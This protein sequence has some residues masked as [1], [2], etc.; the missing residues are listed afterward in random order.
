MHGFDWLAI[1]STATVRFERYWYHLVFYFNKSE[2]GREIEAAAVMW[3]CKQAA[4][5]SAILVAFISPRCGAATDVHFD[6]SG[7]VSNVFGDPF[8]AEFVAGTTA[9]SGHVFY[10]PAS[11]ATD[12][13]AGCDCMGYRQHIPGGFTALVGDT[14][15]SADDYVVQIK[16]DLKQH[17][18]PDD[19]L[20][21]RY[22]GD[23]TP[24]LSSPLQVNGVSYP[25]SLFQINLDS[26]GDTFSDDRL[27][28][29]LDLTKFTSE[30]NFLD[31]DRTDSTLG[32]IFKNLSFSAASSLPPTA[33]DF[34]GDGRVDANDYSMW[35][36]T[37]GSTVALAA[38]GNSNGI[39]DAADYV[40]WRHNAGQLLSSNSV[41][42]PSSGIL[43]LAC[44]LLTKTFRLKTH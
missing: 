22:S 28:A 2:L 24:A 30:Y 9:V 26:A 23:F 39:I 29:S 44:F 25:G 6:F 32:A 15:F 38:D 18:G 7:Y 41:P 10:D 40:V 37:F 19:T 17:W 31:E 5:F 14:Q 43:L 20:S 4:V 11:P 35:R 13:I 27:P 3:N 12:P 16:N 21:V 34:N 36:S 8:H 33:G 42:E 1:T